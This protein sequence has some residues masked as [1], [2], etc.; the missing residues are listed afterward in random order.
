MTP[1]RSVKSRSATRDAHVGFG[2]VATH[3]LAETLNA[4]LADYF[5]LFVKTKGFCWHVPGPN[6]HEHHALLNTQAAETF[7]VI[8]L[9]GDRVRKLGAISILSLEDIVDKQR[10]PKIKRDNLTAQEMF[11]AL[12]EDNQQLLCYLREAHGLCEEHGD[13][14]TCGLL[15]TWID[16]AEARVW[17]LHE[18]GRSKDSADLHRK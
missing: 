12:Y 9:L 5:A 8:D 13:V 7:K 11:D 18:S 1:S 15:S 14:A 17:H 3:E 6:F 4:L 10:V 16:D 2:P